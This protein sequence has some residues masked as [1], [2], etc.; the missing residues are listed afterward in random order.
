MT[1]PEATRSEFS[2]S[3]VDVDEVQ[4]VANSETPGLL[5]TTLEGDVLVCEE[6]GAQRLQL[7]DEE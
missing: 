3:G 6:S 4:W 2:L 7:Q 1:L 5:I